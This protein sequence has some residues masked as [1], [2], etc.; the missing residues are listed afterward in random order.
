MRRA[1]PSTSA[2]VSEAGLTLDAVVD[3]VLVAIELDDVVIVEVVG[4]GWGA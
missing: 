1:K 4:V 2:S 3:V